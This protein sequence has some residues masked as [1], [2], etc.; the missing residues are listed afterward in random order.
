[1]TTAGIHSHILLKIC[2]L[3][4]F[5]CSSSDTHRSAYFLIKCSSFSTSCLWKQ[6]KERRM[7]CKEEN[8]QATLLKT[9]AACGDKTEEPYSLLIKASV[10]KTQRYAG[11]THLFKGF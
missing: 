9:Q 5:N 11:S 10:Q 1:M 2:A 6:I 4:F 3:F 8:Q 7:Y